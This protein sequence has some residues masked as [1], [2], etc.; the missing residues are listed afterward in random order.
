MIF[1]VKV[2]YTVSADI[3]KYVGP[4]FNPIPSEAYILQKKVEL[5]FLGSQIC[6]TETDAGEYVKKVYTFCGF[7]ETEKI[8]EVAFQLEEDVAILQKYILKSIC[9]CFPS[10]FV[11]IEKIGLNFF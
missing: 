1:P 11:P 6:H 3:T 4:A 10:C 5:Q 9:F 8:E 2:P 7:N